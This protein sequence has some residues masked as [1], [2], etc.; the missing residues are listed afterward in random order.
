MRLGSEPRLLSLIESKP[1]TRNDLPTPRN[2]RAIARH[3]Q[4]LVISC[5][6]LALSVLPDARRQ[7]TEAFLQL[8]QRVS[9][10]KTPAPALGAGAGNRETF[11]RRFSMILNE[12]VNAKL[13]KA[14]I[15]AALLLAAIA[16]P[17]WAFH[18]P[19]P[20][21]TT[22][23]K[24]AETI[25]AKPIHTLKHEEKF[26]EGSGNVH[27]VAWSP[28][29]RTLASTT[30]E[31][32]LWSPDGTLSKRGLLGNV[33][34][35]VA[36]SPDGKQLAVGSAKPGPREASDMTARILLLDAKSLELKRKL[37][38]SLNSWVRPVAFSPDGKLL[39]GGSGIMEVKKL[40]GGN[41][42]YSIGSAFPVWDVA[43]GTLI[44]EADDYK[45]DRVRA[46]AFSPDGKTLATGNQYRV[47]LRNPKTWLATKVLEKS[48]GGMGLAF[49]PDGKSLA[50]ANLHNQVQLFDVKSGKLLRTLK[51]PK[52]A[53]M[54]AVAFSPDG[55]LLVSGGSNGAPKPGRK[56]SVGSVLQLWNA[57]TGKLIQSLKD[58]ELQVNR[59]AFN[60]KD[61]NTFASAS[62]DGTVK[63]WRITRK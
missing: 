35:G 22:A 34:F 41:A 12:R 36:F 29:G 3:R 21:E 15:V 51:H 46:I 25:S 38:A 44:V 47:T 32:F 1:I 17:G 62:E 43:K 37:D 18:E 5:D 49:S 10:I 42:I 63:I 20:E 23:D 24:A 13:P 57:R 14:G 61:A 55:K 45:Y 40:K 50:V 27:S 8:S 54:K 19:S 4:V 53:W 58:H 6:A 33:K 52:G 48:L 31:V 59:V 11:K 9:E 16:L 7:F 28:D 2:M 39:L 26:G 30:Y 56:Q 60:P